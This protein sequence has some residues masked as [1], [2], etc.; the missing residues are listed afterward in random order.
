MITVLCGEDD[1]SIQQALVEIKL[2]LDVTSSGNWI[3]FKVPDVTADQLMMSCSTVSLFGEKRNVIVRGLIGL[4]ESNKIKL[5]N[6]H[7]LLALLQSLPDSVDLIFVDGELKKSNPFLKQI[8]D[9]VSIKQ[10][11][12]LKG[13]KLSDW[14]NNKIRHLGLNFRS[15]DVQ[16]F[17]KRA[18]SN[19]WILSN[20][21]EKLSI[22]TMGRSVEKKDIVDLAN[23]NRET[24]LRGYYVQA[25]YFLSESIS[26]WPE[27][28]EMAARFGTY[29]PRDSEKDERFFEKTVAFNY[30]FNGHKNKLTAE[31]SRVSLDQFDTEVGDETIY[32]LQWDVSF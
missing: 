31:V 3:E 20:E 9:I 27:P 21:L 23:N 16:F 14:V 18:G 19:L 26:W 30:F 25:G 28:L 29:S 5:V 4:F 11:P 6:W 1:F 32:S 13:S 12:V 7:N 24:T 15:G 2:K 17:L 8:K 22:Y 10:Y